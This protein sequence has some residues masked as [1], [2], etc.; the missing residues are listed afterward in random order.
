[1]T[2]KGTRNLPAA[3]IKAHDLWFWL[4]NHGEK[5]HGPFGRCS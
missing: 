4:I 5:F 2:D 3:V 1:M